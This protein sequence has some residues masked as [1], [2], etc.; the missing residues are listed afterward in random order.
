MRTVFEAGG[1]PAST[2]TKVARSSRNGTSA[3][4][5]TGCRP[6]RKTGG[7]PESVLEAPIDEQIRIGLMASPARPRRV[8]WKRTRNV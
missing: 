4:P 2:P 5:M 6:R 8:G 3:S 1:G 7:L